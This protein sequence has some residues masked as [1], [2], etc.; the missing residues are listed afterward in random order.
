MKIFFRRALQLVAGLRL[1]RHQANNCICRTKPKYKA[2]SSDIEGASAQ[3]MHNIRDI[4]PGHYREISRTNYFYIAK[5]NN[6]SV[7][8]IV[9]S[10]MRV[11]LHASFKA[12]RVFLSFCPPCQC[13]A[14]WPHRSRDLSCCSRLPISHSLLK[15][16]HEKICSRDVALLT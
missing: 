8:M 12:F 1:G 11:I 14:P 13:T 4:L 6:T 16:R 7:T 9:I 2:P 3:S 15:K 10:L 5:K